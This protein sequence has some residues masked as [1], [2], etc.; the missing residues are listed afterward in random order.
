M[1]DFYIETD[2]GRWN[3]AGLRAIPQGKVVIRQPVPT[4]PTQVIESGGKV[5]GTIRKYETLWIARIKG[6]E[7]RKRPDTFAY[8]SGIRFAAPEGFRTLTQAKKAVKAVLDSRPTPPPA[9]AARS[10]QL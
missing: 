6:H 1:S 7:F 3:P 8:Q 2:T 4:L 9:L 10:Q 5:V